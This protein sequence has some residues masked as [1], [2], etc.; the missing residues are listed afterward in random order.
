MPAAPLRNRRTFVLAASLVLN[1]VL[2]TAVGTAA[3]K[4]AFDGGRPDHRHS[5]FAMPGPRQLKEVLPE[6]DRPLLDAVLDAHRPDIF[7]RIGAVRDGRRA[8]AEVLRREALSPDELAAVLADLRGR[9]AA[10]AEEVYG[11]AADLLGRLDAEGRRA[12]ADLV[13]G[14]PPRRK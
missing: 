14:P 2:L 8:A 9:E 10:V 11:M 13:E 3:V 6:K 12:V 4:G 7:G 1:V 5:P